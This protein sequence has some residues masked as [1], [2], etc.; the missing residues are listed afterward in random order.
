MWKPWI[1]VA[2]G[3]IVAVNVAGRGLAPQSAIDAYEAQ[4][5]VAPSMSLNNMCWNEV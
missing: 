2:I 5:S 1:L 4:N 3:S